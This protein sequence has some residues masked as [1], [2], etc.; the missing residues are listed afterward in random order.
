MTELKV[1]HVGCG[2][3]KPG[4]LPYPFNTSAW[5]EIRLDIDPQ[6]APDILA[7]IT[8]MAQVPSASVDAIFS[9]HTLE[10]LYPHEVPAALAEFRRVL[11]P[12]GFLVITLPDLERVAERIV[13]GSLLDVAYVSPAGP[14]S[15]IDMLYGFRPALAAGNTF[16]AHRCGFTAGSLERA[17]TEIGFAS[18]SVRRD[19]LWSLWAVAAVHLA[20]QGSTAHLAE[21]LA[22]SDLDLGVR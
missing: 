7:S 2:P 10:H 14:V 22:Q 6:A 12:Q 11:T 1:L 17:L 15:P 8:D 4:N 18:V 16:M 9:S 3:K 5:R 21:S 20:D 19:G 13:D